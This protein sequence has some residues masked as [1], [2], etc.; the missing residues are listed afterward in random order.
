MDARA[1]PARPEG[2]TATGA[3][4]WLIVSSISLRNIRSYARL[5]LELEP[6][7]VLVT[8]PNGAGKTNLLESLH[9]G[10]QGFSPRTRSDAQL[11][12]FGEDAGRV[13]LRGRLAARARGDASQR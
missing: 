4:G 12:R 11:I 7:L 1:K 9:V 8:G 13:S 10:T 3:A 5:D 2:G 6:G